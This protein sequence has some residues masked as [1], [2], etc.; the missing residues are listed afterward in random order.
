MSCIH[1]GRTALSMAAYRGFQARGLHPGGLD[2]MPSRHGRLRFTH[3]GLGA[4]RRLGVGRR[5]GGG[6]WA[7]IDGSFKSLSYNRGWAALGR[8]SF[9]P[10]DLRHVHHC[11]FC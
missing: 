4:G 9:H 11:A 10:R 8:T 2:A 1:S 6:L 3:V 7:F 5:L